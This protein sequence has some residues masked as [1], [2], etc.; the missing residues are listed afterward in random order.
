MFDWEAQRGTYEMQGELSPPNGWTS[1]ITGMVFYHSN[2]H[3]DIA[4]LLRRISSHVEIL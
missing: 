3:S 1:S 4:S 2:E